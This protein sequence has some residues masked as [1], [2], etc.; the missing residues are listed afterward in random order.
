MSITVENVEFYLLILVRMSA[1]IFTAPIFSIRSIPMSVKAAISV[2]L[3]MIVATLIPIETLTYTTVFGLAFLVFKEILVGLL[4]GFMASIC[5]KIVSFSG[6]L[7]DMEIGFSMASA[8]DPINQNQV[9]VTG[10]LLT[11]LVML[12]LLV[13]DLHYYL[14]RAIITTYRLIPVGKAIFSLGMYKIMVKFLVDF[15]VIG[16]RIILPVFAAT[17]ITNTVLGILAKVSPQLNMFV[18]GFQLKIFVGLLVLVVIVTMLP[19]ITDYIMTEIKD[20]IEY[21]IRS[22]AG[23]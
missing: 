11:Y 13:T 4:I 12:T 15:F 16:F 1:F 18:V 2:F 7:L 3:T 17:L 19:G 21:T 22:L 20:M 5:T 23:S 6:Q 10:N 14:I 9:T 8:F